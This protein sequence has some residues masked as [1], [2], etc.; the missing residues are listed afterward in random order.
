MHLRCNLYIFNISATLAGATL[1]LN[2]SKRGKTLD[3][4]GLNVSAVLGVLGT[5]VSH[6]ETNILLD[7]SRTESFPLLSASEDAVLRRE[8]S[9][10]CKKIEHTISKDC[11]VGWKGIHRK[12]WGT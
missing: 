11:S 6:I 8:F 12:R 10:V 1:N 3:S 5:G 4:L 2:E 9:E 7:L